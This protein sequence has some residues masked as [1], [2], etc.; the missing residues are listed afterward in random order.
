MASSTR[1]RAVSAIVGV[2]VNSAIRAG[3]APCSTSQAKRAPSVRVFPVPAPPRTSSAPPPLWAAASRCASVR[4]RRGSGT[5]LGYGQMALSPTGRSTSP[6]SA[7]AEWLDA[8]R[9]ATAG[10]R[11]MLAE[12]PTTVQRA[13]ETGRGEGGDEAL[14]IDRAAEDVAVAELD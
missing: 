11:A 2:A 6:N 3:A 4:P 12:H 14:V 5:T 9:M 8:C 1:A 7:H 10:L 13:V